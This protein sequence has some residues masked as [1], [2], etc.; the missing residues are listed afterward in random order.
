MREHVLS[1]GQRLRVI[2]PLAKI[3]ELGDR[4][5]QSGEAVKYDVTVTLTKDTNSVREYTYKG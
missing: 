4:E 3:T 1:N 2:A 5:Y